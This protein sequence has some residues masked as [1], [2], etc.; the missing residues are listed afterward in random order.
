MIFVYNYNSTTLKTENKMLKDKVVDLEQEN[1]ILLRKTQFLNQQVNKIRE[2]EEAMR[3][4]FSNL[5]SLRPIYQMLKEKFPKEDMR[6]ILARYDR[7]EN[8]CLSYAKKVDE[9]EGEIK[10]L[11][12]ER[13]TFQQELSKKDLV[14]QDEEQK[15][16]KII[17]LYRGEI[18]NKDLALREKENYKEDYFKLFN[19]V[20]DLYLD[21]ISG[22]KVYE[23]LYLHDGK[24]KIEIKPDLQDPFEML[25]LM[26]K[27]VKVTTEEGLQK[28]L[29]KV[30]VS[31]NQLLRAYFPEHVNDKFDP[32]KVYERI[33]KYIDKLHYELKKYNPK[34]E[35]IK[36]D[37]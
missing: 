5:E 12:D 17:S 23:G 10:N 26:R 29:K 4:E 24:N 34:Y 13:V 15:R 18:E 19:K 28:Y 1:G 33:H 7:L 20:L 21:W 32:D 6:S 27:L 9:L 25:N 37:D 35:K 31:A 36:P 14:L 16:N 8:Y 3:K 22:V 2:E 30:I 11:R